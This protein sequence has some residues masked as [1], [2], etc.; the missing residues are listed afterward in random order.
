MSDTAVTETEDARRGERLERRLRDYH[1]VGLEEVLEAIGYLREDG[2]TVIAG[3]SLACD[4]GNRLSDLDLVVC[5]P[6]TTPSR[7]PLEHWVRSL[8]VD[9][10]TRSHAGVD[11]LFA[12]AERA[13]AAD[14]PLRGSFGT[15]EEEQQ[16]KLLHRVAFGLRIDGPPLCV[17][18]SR[19]P[20]EIA[21]ALL[22]REYAERMRESAH[23]AQLAA[24][25]GHELAAVTSARSAVEECLQTV[26]AARGVPFTGDKWLQERLRTAAPDLRPLHERFAALPASGTGT[27]SFIAGAVSLCERLTGTDLSVTALAPATR[28]SAPG[29]RLH[30]AGGDHYLVAPAIGGLWALEPAEAEIWRGLPPPADGWRGSERTSAETAFLLDLYIQGLAR[31]DWDRGLALTGLETAS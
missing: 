26:L 2:D 20:A 28:W 5:G 25:T 11:A 19:G 9:A 3:G 12:H 1:G 24:R 27:A 7:V 17:A 22:V 29:L 8:R 18:A 15:A 13:V 21:S 30:T 14:A 16:L 6:A 10:W 4:L 31:L 23:V